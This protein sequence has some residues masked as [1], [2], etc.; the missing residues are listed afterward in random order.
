MSPVPAA[1]VPI[2]M[3]LSVGIFFFYNSLKSTLSLLGSYVGLFA[4]YVVTAALL[5]SKCDL[6]YLASHLVAFPLPLI[7]AVLCTFKFRSRT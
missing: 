2:A 7:A 4:F 3:F 1:F 6:G 5:A